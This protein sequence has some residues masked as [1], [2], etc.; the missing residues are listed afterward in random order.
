M[1]N[2]YKTKYETLV[3]MLNEYCNIIE[4]KSLQNMQNASYSTLV[5]IDSERRAIL[6]E[7]K[8]YIGYQTPKDIVAERELIMKK[9]EIERASREIRAILDELES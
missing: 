1:E 5:E 7:I 6:R 3:D 2:D 4:F 8:H 9:R